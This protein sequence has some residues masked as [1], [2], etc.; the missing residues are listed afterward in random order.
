MSHS[1]AADYSTLTS[2]AEAPSPVSGWR[3]LAADMAAVGGSSVVCQGLGVVNSL[4]LR[5]ALTPAQM[6]V[7]QGLKLLLGY[8][9]YTN[10]GVSKGAARELAIAV[11]SGE[12]ARAQQG[13]NQA[14][15]VN[16]VTSL[17]YGI[18]LAAAGLW[19]ARD[20]GGL[21]ADGWPVG[22]LAL[23]AL[24][25]VQRHLTFHVTILRCKQSF[26]LTSWAS[27]VEGSLTL[28]LAG[29]GAWRWGLPGLY[30][31]TLLTLLATLGYLHWRGVGPLRLAW[32]WSEI[33]RLVAIGGPILLG[34]VAM[35]LLQSLDKLMILAFSSN[36]E[37][38]L[39]CYSTP[40]LITGQIY[41][42]ANMFALVVAPRYGELFGR[43]GRC[44][45]VARLAARA[46]ELLA[47]VTS[48]SAA[49][50]LVVAVPMLACLFPAYRPGLVPATWLVPGIIMLA[51]ALPLN[52]YLVA[53]CR[54]RLAMAAAV[55]A[56]AVGAVADGAV[57][58]MGHG[59]MGVAAC[60]AIVYA[61][62]YLLLLS[63]SIWPRLDAAARRRYLATH[64]VVLLFPLAPALWLTDVQAGSIDFARL[65][66]NVVVVLVAWGLVA[67]AGWRL[68][69][70]NTA[71]RDGN[72]KL[73]VASCRFAI[74]DP[75]APNPQ[76][77]IPNPQSPIP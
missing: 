68:A 48:L 15:T 34:G 1:S 57:L 60:T 61:G 47:A 5:A 51:L 38:D 36:R 33:R 44:D 16:T 19:L 12:T 20:R 28:G 76:S 3:R 18:A 25:V 46:S 70:W 23:G 56:L 42:L 43:T 54:E 14:C 35:A 73:Q 64:I 29:L 32:Q 13:L 65:G 9:N 4:V 40:L 21:A 17:V 27:L 45:E 7:W 58:A 63:I 39:G 75:R 37:F 62:Y 22:L 11:G 49:A 69:D 10:L 71:W 67:A 2:L 66:G 41:G 24:V 74:A 31:G 6:G 8:A 59:I 52:Q 77:P 26:A 72:C 55:A 50:G 53:V 30:G